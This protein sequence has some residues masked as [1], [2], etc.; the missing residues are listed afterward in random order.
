[1]LQRPRTDIIRRIIPGP[2]LA[3]KAATRKKAEDGYEYNDWDESFSTCQQYS[4]EEL[5]DWEEEAGL[6]TFLAGESDWIHR[7]VFEDSDTLNSHVE[8]EC[9]ADKSLYEVYLV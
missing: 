9:S 4:A 7:D 6:E 8:E 5:D 1:M 3:T 2:G